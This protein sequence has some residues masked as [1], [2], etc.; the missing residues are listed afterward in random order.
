LQYQGGQV[1][2]EAG[3]ELEPVERIVAHVRHDEGQ[4]AAGARQAVPREGAHGV[5]HSGIPSVRRFWTKAVA[6]Q[7][8]SG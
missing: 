5:V 7:T 8:G 3:R 2:R 4:L 1:L 6:C